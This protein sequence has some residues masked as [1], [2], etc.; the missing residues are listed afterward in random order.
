MGERLTD[1][2]VIQ[3]ALVEFHEK[4]AR[5]E[6]DIFGGKF[7]LQSVDGDICYIE[8]S[9]VASELFPDSSPDVV[10]SGIGMFVKL[11]VPEG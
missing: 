2:A 9:D 7:L 11:F 3:N 5:Y 10:K 6:L 4:T 8:P 1:P